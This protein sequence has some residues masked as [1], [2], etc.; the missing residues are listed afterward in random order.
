MK[1]KWIQLA[2]LLVGGATMLQN[3]CVSSF[4]D[5]FLNTGWPTDNRILNVAID[6]LNEELFG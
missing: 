6:V 1:R 3:G 4:F 5:G 2:T